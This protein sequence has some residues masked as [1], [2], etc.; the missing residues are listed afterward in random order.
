[1]GYC[2]YRHDH[3]AFGRIVDGLWNLGLEKPLS[4]ESLV[5]C[6]IGA[7]ETRM[8]RAVHKMEAWFVKFQREV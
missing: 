5:D 2:C 3:V 8:L 7:L 1:M 6:S 4:V